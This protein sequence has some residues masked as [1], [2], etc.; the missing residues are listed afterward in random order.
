MSVQPSDNEDAYFQKRD[1]ELRAQLR[2]QLDK[3]AGELRNDQDAAN[4]LSLA[5]RISALGFTGDKLKVF[6]ILPLIHVAWADGSV[7]RKE[8]AAILGVLR[9]RGIEPGTDAFRT[10]ESLLEER[11]SQTFLDQSLAVLKEAVGGARA[12][13]IV[14]LCVQ[15][16]GASGGFLNIGTISDEERALI[17]SIASQLGGAAVAEFNKQLG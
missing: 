5:E 14:D 12:A 10:I 7:S 3:A 16:A 15:I 8:R 13:S 17:E 6:D 4:K 1:Q 11:P 9:G 2:E